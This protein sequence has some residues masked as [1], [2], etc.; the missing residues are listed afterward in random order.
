MN[1]VVNTKK[2][3]TGNYEQKWLYV[4]QA[5]EIAANFLAKHNKWMIDS[6]SRGN[7]PE[8]DVIMNGHKVEIKFQASKKLSIEYATAAGEM[9]GIMLTHAKYYLMINQGKSNHNG[10]WVD[11]GKVRLIKVAD[12]K[13][14]FLKNLLAGESTVYHPVANSSEPGSRVV[15]INPK[16]DLPNYTDGWITD[17][18][19]TININ[20]EV[21]YHF[22]D[23]P[24][25]KP[26]GTNTMP[27]DS[28]IIM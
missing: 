21:E 4:N 12:L 17:I 13:K 5:E 26:F 11:V 9:S 14:A 2:L 18:K 22:D 28:L 20:G 25:I 15:H 24:N 3:Y 23:I 8:Y 1:Y 10:M 27:V 6:Y 7:V 16:N 19:Y